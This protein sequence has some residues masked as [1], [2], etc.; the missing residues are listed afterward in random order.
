MAGVER[1]HDL[2]AS[3]EIF[4]KRPTSAFIAGFHGHEWKTIGRLR[5]ALNRTMVANPGVLGDHIRLLNA[6][7]AAIRSRTRT[8]AEGIDINREFPTGHF[9]SAEPCCHPSAQ[10]IIDQFRRFPELQI[11]WSF[12]GEAD[13]PGEPAKPFY[14]YDTPR[15]RNVPSQ[16]FFFSL[17]QPLLEKIKNDPIFAGGFPSGVHSGIDCVGLGNQVVDG[18][19]YS[20]ANEPMADNGSFESWAASTPL[21]P[22]VERTVLFEIP[23][24]LPLHEQQRM[25]Q[26]I[27]NDLVIPF[28]RK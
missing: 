11:V 5:T 14:M 28:S 24:Y 27:I 1:E 23:D 20:P 9:R 25:I 22:S 17:V 8:S 6:H 2:S 10:E 15:D 4:G 13:E 7:P 26:L 18:Y 19:I 16:Q 12:H 21:L 3:V